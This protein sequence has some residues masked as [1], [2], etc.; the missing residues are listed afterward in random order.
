MG[1]RRLFIIRKDLHMSP[2]KLTVQLM[3]QAEAYW[4]SMIREAAFPVEFRE[5]GNTGV[6]MAY[7][8]NQNYTHYQAEIVIPKNVFEEYMNDIFVKTV[9]QARNKNHLLKAK[10]MAENM[11][12]IEGSDFGLIYDAC[13]TELEPEEKDGTILTGIWFKPLPDDVAH[14]ISKKYQL[15]KGD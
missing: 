8:N 11:D 10:T 5:Y 2:G 3:H 9:C 13:L 4:T 1:Y 14:S 7:E 6:S 12:L 15:Y